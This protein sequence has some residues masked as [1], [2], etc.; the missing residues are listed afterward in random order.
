[1][2]MFRKSVAVSSIG[3]AALVMMLAAPASAHPYGDFEIDS[4]T[5]DVYDASSSLVTSIPI[6]DTSGT[7]CGHNNDIDFEESPG[8]DVAANFSSSFELLNVNGNPSEDYFATLTGTATGTYSGTSGYTVS[9]AIDVTAHLLPLDGP[10]SGDELGDDCTI[11]ATGSG[12]PVI[13]SG[14]GTGN[15]HSLGTGN[16]LTI[17]AVNSPFQLSVTGDGCGTFIAA[18]NGWVDLVDI[19]LTNFTP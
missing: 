7:S 6:S 3:A 11:A 17:D 14:I 13:S 10:C 12:A 5:V 15:P 2:S 19:V 4:G 9:G 18:N 8:N 1:M 16:T